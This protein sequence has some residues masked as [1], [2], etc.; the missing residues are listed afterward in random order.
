MWIFLRKLKFKIN[1]GVFDISLNYCAHFWGFFHQLLWW[2]I[3]G[4]LRQRQSAEEN[5]EV[6]LELLETEMGYEK[7]V[8]KIRRFMG[9][10]LN[11]FEIAEVILEEFSSIVEC[12]NSIVRPYINK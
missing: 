10:V 1:E 4:K 5:I 3:T 2:L 11:Y 12:I 8:K 6:C 9:D 7:Q